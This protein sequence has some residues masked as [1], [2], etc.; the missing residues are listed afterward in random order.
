MERNNHIISRDV[1]CLGTNGDAVAVSVGYKV[2]WLA[3]IG[4]CTMRTR[5]WSDEWCGSEKRFDDVD[6]GVS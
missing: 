4:D 1:G 6:W 3:L 5:G 2:Y